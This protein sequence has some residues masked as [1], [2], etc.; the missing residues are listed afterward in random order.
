MAVVAQWGPVRVV[1]FNKCG[2]TSVINMFL[3]PRGET[4]VR[5]RSAVLNSGE[6][7]KKLGAY[8]GDL[9]ACKEWPDPELVVAFFREPIRRAL[10]A[11]QHFIVRTSRKPF[12]DLGFTADMSFKDFVMHLRKIDLSADAH[13]EPQFLAFDQATPKNTRATLYRIEDLDLAWPNMVKELGLNCT[14]EVMHYNQGNY[15]PYQ[16][17][18][19][20]EI[21]EVIDDL[22][23]SDNMVWHYLGDVH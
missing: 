5:G 23:Q 8:R 4:P 14:T 15:D 7:A 1:A 21:V 16:Y 22:Y 11:Y 13:L 19:D 9:A 10:S 6:E 18:T 17:I 20:P 3:T 12:Q 2:H